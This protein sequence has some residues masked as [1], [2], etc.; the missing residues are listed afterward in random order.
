MTLN[1]SKETQEKY[2]TAI[3]SPYFKFPNY[4]ISKFRVAKL[5]SVL[6]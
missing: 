1:F 5:Q 6:I 3:K 4:A 2:Q